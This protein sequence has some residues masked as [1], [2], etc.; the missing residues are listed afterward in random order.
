MQLPDQTWT[1]A[2]TFCNCRNKTNEPIPK[3]HENPIPYYINTPNAQIHHS[4]KL[5]DLILLKAK[6]LKNHK[7]VPINQAIENQNLNDRKQYQKSPTTPQNHQNDPW[8][9]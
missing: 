3:Q 7:N 1:T 4:Q 9:S 5:L 8:D 6:G 2:A